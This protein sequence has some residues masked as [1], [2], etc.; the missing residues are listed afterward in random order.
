MNALS[1]ADWLFVGAG[2]RCAQPSSRHA[3]GKREAL[4]EADIRPLLSEVEAVTCST[5][6]DSETVRPPRGFSAPLVA[7]DSLLLE[8]PSRGVC[9]PAG[10]AAGEV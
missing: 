4:R 5:S 2:R 8:E 7:K 6:R 3:W 10:G 9:T 1:G